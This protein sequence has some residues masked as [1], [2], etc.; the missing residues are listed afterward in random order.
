MKKM[1]YKKIFCYGYVLLVTCIVPFITFNKYFDLTQSKGMSFIVGSVILLVFYLIASGNNESNTKKIKLSLIEKACILLTFSAFISTV[2]AR[3][4][5]RAIWGD[6][7]TYM[8]L[9]SFVLGLITLLILVRCDVDFKPLIKPIIGINIALFSLTIAHACG[10]DILHLHQGIASQQ[11]YDYLGTMGNVN[12]I[13]GY[14]SMMFILTFYHYITNDSKDNYVYF[15]Y[16]V[17]LCIN[18]HLVHSDAIYL[19]LAC[20]AVFLFPVVCNNR[21]NVLKTLMVIMVYVIAGLLLNLCPFDKFRANISGISTMMLR[22]SILLTIL[23][24]TSMLFAYIIQR[25][26]T[27]YR[28]LCFGLEVIV[29]SALLL[30]IFDLVI[31]Y[32]SY[33]YYW[34]NNRLNTWVKS[35]FYYKHYYTMMNQLFGVG[36]DMLYYVYDELSVAYGATLINAHNCFI[37]VL[38]SLGIIGLLAFAGLLVSVIYTVYKKG[39]YGK[40]YF[41]YFVALV[42]FFGQSLVNNCNGNNIGLLIVVFALLIKSLSNTKEV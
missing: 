18:I 40:P 2:F 26:Q 34:G 3:P 7:G 5:A 24:I 37:Q 25:K 22:P 29:I 28:A 15:I 32:M 38:L 13:V 1:N 30:V 31:S 12:W 41:S 36:P 17:I 14:L 21:N 8:G 35:L 6:T 27:N 9:F 16:L 4:I 20:A 23:I 39:L 33:N 42:A 11:Y 10:V 19:A